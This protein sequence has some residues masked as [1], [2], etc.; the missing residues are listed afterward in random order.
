MKDKKEQVPY[1]MLDESDD[2]T[3]S[4]PPE[5]AEPA[6]GATPKGDKKQDEKKSGLAGLFGKKAKIGNVQLDPDIGRSLSV[7]NMSM[8]C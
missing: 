4:P 8:R 5:Y 6:E 7:T 1:H 3:A 2:E